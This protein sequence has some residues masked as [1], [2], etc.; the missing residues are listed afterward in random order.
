M[1]TTLALDV[2]VE[3]GKYSGTERIGPVLE[4][5]LITNTCRGHVSTHTLSWQQ[6]GAHELKH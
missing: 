3:T 4:A 2:K 6:D 1:K 5:Y